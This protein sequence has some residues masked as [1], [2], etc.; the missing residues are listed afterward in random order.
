MN[1]DFYYKSNVVS[2]IA[3]GFL[4]LWFLIDVNISKIP[5]LQELEVQDQ[6]VVAYILIFVIFLCLTLSIIEFSRNES[7]SWQSKLQIVIFTAIPLIAL[8]ISYPKLIENTFLQNTTRLELFI[9]CLSAIFTSIVA[10]LLN[11]EINTTLVFYKFRKTVYF[12]MIIKLIFLSVLIILGIISVDW[13]GGYGDIGTF[14][15]RYVIFA[16]VFLITYIFLVPKKNIYSTEE[17]K[18]L[19]KYSDYLDREVEVSE[20]VSSLR[21]PPPGLR[22]RIY[23][24]IMARINRENDKDR[25]SIFPR[26]I[27][28]K[29]ITFK[30]LGDRS[31][32]ILEGANDDDPVIKM[33]L[34]RKDTQEILNTKDIKFKY[35]KMVCENVP[36]LKP[37]NDIRKFINSIAYNAFLLQAINES[38]PDELMLMYASSDQNLSELKYLFKNK[39]PN[40]NHI[41]SNGWTALL[42]SVANGAEKNAKYLLQ[43]AADPNI[44][45]KYGATSLHFAAQYGKLSLC[46]LLVHYKAD[47]N[48]RD[49]YGRTTLMLASKFG[50]T[51]VVNFLIQTGADSQLKDDEAKTALNYAIE[52]NYGEICK[53]LK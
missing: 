2:I 6:Q 17:L 20:Y 38:H 50:H 43:K 10:L 1:Q 39:N 30:E 27:V 22:K 16:I 19:E 7:N 29:Q 5:A 48:Q 24:K 26:F 21:K 25:K 13:Y 47:V 33:N 8:F 40:I 45:T 11:I 4:I 3:S 34:I 44:S 9:S 51:S 31:I 23:K 15:I 14:P 35:V 28:L 18:K 46:K 37:E 32:P 49:V 12:D 41:A 52:G 53:L 36:K 42:V